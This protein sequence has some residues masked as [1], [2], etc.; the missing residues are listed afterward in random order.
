MVYWVMDEERKRK[1]GADERISTAY[2]LRPTLGVRHDG[3]TGV[4]VI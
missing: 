3:L 2:G 4:G 1:R